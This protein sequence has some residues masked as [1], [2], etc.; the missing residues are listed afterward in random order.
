MPDDAFMGD[1]D[2][3]KAGKKKA[4][5]DRLFCDLGANRLRRAL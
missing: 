1:E 4:G 5:I 3:K 2:N